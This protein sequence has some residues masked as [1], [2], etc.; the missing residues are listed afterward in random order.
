MLNSLAH[1]AL[2]YGTPDQCVWKYIKSL[3]GFKGS[4]KNESF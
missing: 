1:M 4:I 2:P 3:L